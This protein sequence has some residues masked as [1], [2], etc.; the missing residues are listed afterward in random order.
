MKN[1]AERCCV[2]N[3]R[4]LIRMK[5]NHFNRV[6]QK[7]EKQATFL[8]P[9]QRVPRKYKKKL[10]KIFPDCTLRRGWTIP[11]LHK[12]EQ[13]ICNIRGKE[14]EALIDGVIVIFLI[15]SNKK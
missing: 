2:C 12:G 6:C 15:N 3:S 13:V 10:K 5:I 11:Q 14:I 7:H 1:K 9:F 8:V 4:N